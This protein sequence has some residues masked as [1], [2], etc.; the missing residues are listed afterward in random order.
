MPGDILVVHDI[1]IG[2]EVEVIKDVAPPVG[3]YVL[4]EVSDGS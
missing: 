3:V 4:F 1:C 2:L